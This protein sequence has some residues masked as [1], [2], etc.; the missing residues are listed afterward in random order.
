[1]S[2]GWQSATEMPGLSGAG[3]P[4]GFMRIHELDS[5]TMQGFSSKATMTA[6]TRFDAP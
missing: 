2:L 5:L 3:G 6:R 1:M 4:P